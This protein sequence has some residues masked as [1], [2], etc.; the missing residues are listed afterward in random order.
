MKVPS[1]AVAAV[2]GG[3][4]LSC[5]YINTKLLRSQEKYS[6]ISDI[7]IVMSQHDCFFEVA[8]VR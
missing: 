5:S 1:E 7:I 4:F 8:C 6:I 2:F 3:F